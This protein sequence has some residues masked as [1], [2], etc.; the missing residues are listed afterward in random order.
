MIMKPIA[1][2]SGAGAALRA[3]IKDVRGNAA[4]EVALTCTALLIFLFGIIEVGFAMWLQSAL[5][6]SVAEA[7]RCASVN[8]TLCGT[9]SAI[10]SYAANK[11][12]AGFNSSVFS[13]S[14]PSCGNQVSASYPLALTIPTMSVSLTLS[15]QSC[16]P[17]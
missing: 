8:P 9:T 17:S 10:Q 6:Y 16:F 12:G 14:T 13:V 11:S 2:L 1:A 15:A 7:A 3:Q 5:N 4:V